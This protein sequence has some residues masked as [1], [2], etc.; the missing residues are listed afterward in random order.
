MSTRTSLF[1]SF[2]FP[3]QSIF[4]GRANAEPCIRK[5]PSGVNLQASQ[6]Q[7]VGKRRESKKSRYG[8]AVNYGI[9]MGQSTPKT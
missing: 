3:A 6:S 7:K 1:F 2:S 4:D 9:A 5:C 8:F